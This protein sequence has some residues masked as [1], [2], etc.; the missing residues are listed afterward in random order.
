MNANKLTNFT[1]VLHKTDRASEVSMFDQSGNPSSINP[2]GLVIGT[3]TVAEALDR[4]GIRFTALRAPTSG[5]FDP[6]DYLETSTKIQLGV[7]CYTLGY[8]SP[9]DGGGND[10][11]IVAAGTGTD[12]GGSFIN[13]S[14]SGL[15]AKGLFGATV[16][17]K[18]FGAIGDGVADDTA[19][20][21]GAIAQINTA[22]Q[23]MFIPA[24][25]FRI[26]SNLQTVT[27]YCS[28]RGDSRSVTRLLFEN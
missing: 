9:G 3:Q 11:E 1:K 15:Q 5:E 19:P 21:N 22:S 28:V 27:R 18:Q 6:E 16:N 14:G 26:T 4:R 23:E 7:F 17:V 12:D 20:F 2:G 25:I 24:G 13:L 8:Y 10:Y